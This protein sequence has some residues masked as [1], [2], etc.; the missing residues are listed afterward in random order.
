[1]TAGSVPVRGK[2][3][4]P[5]HQFTVSRGSNLIGQATLVAIMVLTVA[6]VGLRYLLNLP[7]LG[8]TEIT[9]YMMVCL[10]LGMAWCALRGRH[11][12]VDLIIRRFPARIQAIVSSITLSV[13]LAVYI[14]ITWR[15]LLEAISVQKTH[16]AS[17][18]LKISTYPFYYV[19]AFGLFMLCVVMVTL[20]AEN[21]A[22][23]V[24]R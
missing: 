19:L 22:K 20:I 14:I 15:T 13:S 11:I 5:L 9:E 8:S 2:Q 10:V 4:S 6:D 24:K 7:I 21:I 17:S 12:K 16:L 1:M 3:D 18:I 23:A